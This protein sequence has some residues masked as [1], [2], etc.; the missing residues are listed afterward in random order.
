[1]TQL[2]DEQAKEK[3][4]EQGALWLRAKS[5]LLAKIEEIDSATPYTPIEPLWWLDM[6][7]VKTLLVATERTSRLRASAQLEALQSAR[8]DLERVIDRTIGRSQ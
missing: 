3:Q 6:M 4:D 5:A 2:T 1:M 8:R 7:A